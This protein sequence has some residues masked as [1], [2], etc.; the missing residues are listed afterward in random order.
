MNEGVDM[1]P[2]TRRKTDP[3]IRTPEQNHSSPDRSDII[4]LTHSS[5]TATPPDFDIKP[6]VKTPKAGDKSIWNN[7]NGAL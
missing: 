3:I 5:G 6:P 2:G 1:Q 4:H 7:I